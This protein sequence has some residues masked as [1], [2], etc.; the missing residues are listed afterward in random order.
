MSDRPPHGQA[1]T[2]LVG[3]VLWF[4]WLALLGLVGPASEA[5]RTVTA[6]GCL[7]IA[8]LGARQQDGMPA[9]LLWSGLALA[10]FLAPT[11]LGR[12]AAYPLLG[13]AMLPKPFRS[14]NAWTALALFAVKAVEAL[15]SL[16]HFVA[17]SLGGLASATV[18]GAPGAELSTTALAGAPLL[19]WLRSC[20]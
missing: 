14:L 18:S 17:E 3:M 20:G 7:A 15:P 11:D 16:G 6:A 2:V 5:E 19:R 13:H 4:G 10:L 12:A 8:S 1:T 9:R